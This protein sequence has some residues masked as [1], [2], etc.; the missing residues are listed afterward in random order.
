MFCRQC[1]SEIP[2]NAKFCTFCGTKVIAPTEETESLKP[3][4]QSEE[5]SSYEGNEKNVIEAEQANCVAPD[6]ASLGQEQAAP[7]ESSN[8]SEAKSLKAAVESN[9]KRS[10]RHVPMIVLIALALALATSVA[11]AAYRVYTD[12]WLPYQAEQ[13]TKSAGKQIGSDGDE[14][15]AKTADEP[16]SLLHIADILEMDPNKIS[17]YIESQGVLP[18]RVDSG[19]YAMDGGFLSSTPFD[20]WVLA[21]DAT[22]SEITALDD[23]DNYLDPSY[24]N[25]SYL[26]VPP[27]IAM[28]DSATPFTGVSQSYFTTSDLAAGKKPSSIV[29]ASLSLNKLSDEKLDEFLSYC[30]FGKP[31]AETKASKSGVLFALV[32]SG[33]IEG[34][35]G[36]NY[37]WYA[38]CHLG[39]SGGVSTCTLGCMNLDTAYKTLGISASTSVQ[40]S[41]PREYWDNASNKDRSKII[42]KSIL[43][44]EYPSSNFENVEIEEN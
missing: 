3:E 23:N 2:S 39:K 19:K 1:G 38:Y 26:S 43:E 15:S 40:P 22:Y 9:K 37:L 31:L 25:Q 36:E 21:Q 20:A 14:I 18:Q 28:G 8:S 17:D 4:A 5:E 10:R 33:V 44:H 24:Y 12:V 29:L 41:N 11:Y 30:G 13:E 16:E 34:V 35:D 42:S 27:V 6:S 32:K 7:S